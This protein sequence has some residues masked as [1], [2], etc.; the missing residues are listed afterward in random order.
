MD[1]IK[2]SDAEL[3]SYGGN[4][5]PDYRILKEK[6]PSVYIDGESIDWTLDTYFDFIYTG[7]TTD[8]GYPLF[9]MFLKAYRITDGDEFYASFE[10]LCY[11]TEDGNVIK[12]LPKECEPYAPAVLYLY[13]LKVFSPTII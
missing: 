12:I 11:V 7:Y 4:V 13:N 6:Y 1:A 9:G 10:G 2:N 3:Y 8:E 5:E